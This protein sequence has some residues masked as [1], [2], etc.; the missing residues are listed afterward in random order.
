MSEGDRHFIPI[1]EF[2]LF[3]LLLL[4]FWVMRKQIEINLF[5]LVFVCVVESLTIIAPALLVS[6]LGWE[7]PIIMILISGTVFY[8]SYCLLREVD[9]AKPQGGVQ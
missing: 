2:L 6:V 9:E 5:G 4:L 7:V 1:F 3:C 8:Y